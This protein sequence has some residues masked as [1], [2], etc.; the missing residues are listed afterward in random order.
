MSA[1]FDLAEDLTQPK[2]PR[3]HFL[4]MEGSRVSV[5]DRVSAIPSIDLLRMT[6]GT[7]LEVCARLG[8]ALDQKSPAEGMKRG[9]RK[10]AAF[11]DPRI[12]RKE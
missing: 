4:A 8:R 5:V 7:P 1:V 10:A 2:V 11:D 9:G 6:P 12:P 3:V